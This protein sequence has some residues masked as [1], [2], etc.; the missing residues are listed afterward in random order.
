[1]PLL[2]L[3]LFPTAFEHFFTGEING[4]FSDNLKLRGGP[5]YGILTDYEFYLRK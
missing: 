4:S 3:Y 2:H 5:L 1:M